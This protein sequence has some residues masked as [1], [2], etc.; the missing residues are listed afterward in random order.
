MPWNNQSFAKVA[1][2]FGVRHADKLVFGT[3]N[4]G[5][6]AGFMETFNVHKGPPRVVVVVSVA[7]V[8][9]LM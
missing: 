3:V 6:M 9:C 8:P 5:Q 2:D 4:R 1:S 7:A